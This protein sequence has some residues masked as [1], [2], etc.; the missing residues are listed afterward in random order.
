MV[1]KGDLVQEWGVSAREQWRRDF[2]DLN[3]EMAGVQGNRLKRFTA[4]LG[5]PDLSAEDKEKK[6]QDDWYVSQ[7]LRQIDEGYRRSYARLFDMINNTQKAYLLALEDIQAEKEA[8]ALALEKIRANALVLGDDRRVYF[9]RDGSKLYDEEGQQITDD[10]MLAEA[11]EAQ[12]RKPDASTHEENEQGRETFKKVEELEEQVFEK[13]R[14]LEELKTRMESREL[15]QDDL[16]REAQGILE[17]MSPEVRTLFD[18]VHGNSPNNVD[19]E[20]Q[21]SMKNSVLSI[22]QPFE[23]AGNGARHIPNE[24][25]PIQTSLPLPLNFQS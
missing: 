21:N 1:K 25:S 24:P 2:T 15:S 19:G 17:G 16:D 18:R 13:L 14:E 4:G 12:E 6:D 9:T 8:A 20:T 22:Q 10:G 7:Y 3:R 23:K 5:S 11:R